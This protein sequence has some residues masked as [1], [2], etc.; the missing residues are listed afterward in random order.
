VGSL[1]LGSAGKKDLKKLPFKTDE[2]KKATEGEQCCL[3][4]RPRPKNITL[5]AG[6]EG[7]SKEGDSLTSGGEE[8][9]LLQEKG[10]KAGPINRGKRKKKNEGLK[11]R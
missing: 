2:G 3:M 7:F 1:S 9:L 8:K 11:S 5:G 6:G 4:V 10:A